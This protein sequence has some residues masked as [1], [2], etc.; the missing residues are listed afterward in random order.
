MTVISKIEKLEKSTFAEQKIIQYIINNKD[1]IADLN[2]AEL[3]EETYTSNAA[4]IRLCHKLGFDGYK[5]FK[6]DLIKDNEKR[7]NSVKN[8]NIN[9]PFYPNESNADITKRIAELSKE[10]I[11]SCYEVICTEKLEQIAKAIKN[12]EHVFIYALGDTMISAM[13]FANRLIKIKKRA[14][15]INEYGES[16][17]NVQSISEKDVVI[18]ISY[19]GQNTLEEEYIEVIRKNKGKLILITADNENEKF[20]LTLTFP[21]KEAQ[22]GKI[23]T[24]Y[25]QQAIH[26]IF[27]CIYAMIFAEDY[28]KNYHLI[29]QM[30]GK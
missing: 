21:N 27:N 14:T 25:S 4:I 20:D 23:A 28:E 18:S 13:S 2:L 22:F 1:K 3:A 9:F 30:Q 10:A 24:Y 29:E 6:I 7:R 11:D 15:I 19:S 17:A 26:Y 8:I 5:S 12:A 16:F